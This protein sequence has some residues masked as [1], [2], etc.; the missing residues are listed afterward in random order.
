MKTNVAASRAPHSV[1]FE[2]TP[3]K[4]LTDAQALRR[5]LMSCMLWEDQ[6]YES[7]RA[8]GDRIRELTLA[9]DPSVA[10]QLAI[11]ARELFK[12]R[13]APLWV[14]CSLSY[15]NAEQRASV[16]SLL[17]HIVQRPDELTGFLALYW[18]EGKHPLS[19]A[20]KR[21]LAK[22][23]QK[24]NAYS[25]AKY[26]QNDAI[27]LRDVLFLVH[28]KPK[29]DEQA[30]T[31][32][33]LAE[34]KLPTPDTWE[35]ALSAGS[36]KREAWVRLIGEGKLGALALLRN[37]RG[38]QEAGV[39]LDV[40]RG[41]LASA[42]VERVLPFRF[43]AAARYAPKLEP[44]LESA[45]FRCLAGMPRLAGTT[46][47]VVDTSPSMWQARVSARSE[48]DRFDAAAALAVLC[49]EICEQVNV[50]AFN[51][52]AYE[53]PARRGFALRDALSATKGGASCGG[54]AV[55]M[56]N[57]AGYDRIIVLT[58][59]EWHYMDHSN[60]MWGH[61]AKIAHEVSPA[62]LTAKAYMVNVAAQRNAVGSSKWV[63]IDGWSEAIIDYIQASEMPLP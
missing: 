6:F 13:H 33:Q 14:A 1:T 60:P 63:M 15:G 50:Y 4:R 36:D 3:A 44:E 41:G 24:F 43:V 48:M 61:Y 52:R 59:G 2:G 38:M 42:N 40:I 32:K 54:L 21:G 23:F 51:E 39:P 56:A 9:V 49:R 35:V 55:E 26:N 30:A 27:K 57:K 53:V 10:C 47:I 11:E 12:L 16:S 37:L 8:I 45:M 25:L 58:D 17:E 20:I 19:A 5:A 18:K 34:N 22:A 62:P 46:A 28:P 29:D 7:G 31:W